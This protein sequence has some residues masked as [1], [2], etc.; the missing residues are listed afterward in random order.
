[1]AGIHPLPQG[2]DLVRII[3][4]LRSFITLTGQASVDVEVFYQQR[5]KNVYCADYQKHG[6][7]CKAVL[8]AQLKIDI[9]FDDFGPYLIWDSSLGP[10]PIRLLVMPDP[11]KPYWSPDWKTTDNSDFGRRK[12]SKNE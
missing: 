7:M 12:Y 6:E 3:H 10:A 1:M 5:I 9:F 11:Y 2:L 8:L 4:S